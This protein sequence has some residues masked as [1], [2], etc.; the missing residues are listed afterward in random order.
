M[1]VEQALG[2]SYQAHTALRVFSLAFPSI[3]GAT[4]AKERAQQRGTVI[5]EYRALASGA[6]IEARIRRQ[7]VEHRAA[8]AALGI[9]RAIDDAPNPRMDDRRRAHRA[10]L[11]G[12]IE[13]RP[14]QPIVFDSLGRRPQG[15][16]LGMG[17]RILVRDG[18]VPALA[19]DLAVAQDQRPDWNLA[20]FSGPRG[21]PEGVPHPV[22][23]P[24]PLLRI[25]AWG[26]GCLSR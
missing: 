12:D 7:Q 15:L 9:A 3:A 25:Q 16:D 18:L 6:M 22:S 23:M 10:G 8:G 20:V 19:D 13:I 17:G 26:K 11:Q 2:E 5:G 4:G 14:R 1:T 21:K 24:P